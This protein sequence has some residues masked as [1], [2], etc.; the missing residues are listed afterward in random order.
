MRHFRRRYLVLLPSPISELGGGVQ[1]A[2]R[3]LATVRHPSALDRIT[4]LQSAAN[5]AESLPSVAATAQPKLHAT[6]TT[7]CEPILF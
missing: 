5:L 3:E 7:D 6:A 1:A 2:G 4:S